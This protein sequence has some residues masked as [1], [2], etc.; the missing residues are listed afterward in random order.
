MRAHAHKPRL[1]S[2]ALATQASLD[3]DIR[4]RRSIL[5]YR[6]LMPALTMCAGTTDRWHTWSDRQ[7]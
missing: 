4:L 2:A 6:F 1:L 7:W 5:M 3:Y